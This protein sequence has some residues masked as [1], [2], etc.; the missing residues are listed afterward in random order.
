DVVPL[1]EQDRSR[2]DRAQIEEGAALLEGVL[3]DGALGAYALQAAIAAVHARAGRAE[4]TAWGEIAALYSMLAQVRP[5][6]VVELN[7][8][9]TGRPAEHGGGLSPARLSIRPAPVR[10]YYEQ[11]GGI[12]VE[13]MLLFMERK[14]APKGEPGGPAEMKKFAGELASQGKLRRGAPLVAESAGAR[15]RVRDGKAFVSDGPFAESKEIVGGFW[16]IE[17]ASREEAIEIARRCPHARHGVVEVHLVRWRDTA[18]DPE[19]GIP[20]LFAFHTEPGL[21][22]PDGSKMRE[23]IG[24]GE[25]LKRDGK[26]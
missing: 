26:F 6:P 7:R 23:M 2:W 14:G 11:R 8:A 16:I 18:A 19:K 10:L 13:F 12:S 21:T 22:D 5:S 1:E 3:R 9:T 15:V 25:A 17:A 24:F 4:D 20:F